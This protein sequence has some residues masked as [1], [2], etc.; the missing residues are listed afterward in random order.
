MKKI[1]SLFTMAFLFAIYSCSPT[2]KAVTSSKNKINGSYTLVS[3]EY[4]NTQD[5]FNSVL[6]G[7][8][9]IDC[10]RGSQWNFI[11]NN[12]S[13][14]YTIQ[15]NADCSGATRNIKW[16][17]IDEGGQQFFQFKRLEDGFKAKDIT[18]GYRLQLTSITADGI[19]MIQSANANGQSLNLIY[20]FTKN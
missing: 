6:F 9:A 16:N 1:I 15:S 19:Q 17:L 14:K 11:E 13:G 8:A 7:E 10:F 5:K 4:S 18:A 3:I 20:T 2:Q 12:N